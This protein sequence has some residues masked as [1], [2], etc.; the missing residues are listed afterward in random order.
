MTNFR[1]LKKPERRYSFEI[2]FELFGVFFIISIATFLIPIF[3][4]TKNPSMAKSDGFFS[5]IDF[6]Y[7]KHNFYPFVL[8]AGLIG[9]VIYWNYQ[10]RKLKVVGFDFEENNVILTCRNSLTG[11][12][13]EINILE[14]NFKVQKIHDLYRK[15]HF[16]IYNNEKYCCSFYPKSEVWNSASDKET[17]SQLIALLTGDQPDLTVKLEENCQVKSIFDKESIKAILLLSFFIGL[18]IY[19]FNAIELIYFA[20]FVSLLLFVQYVILRAIAISTFALNE[21]HV[22]WIFRCK[23]RKIKLK[24]SD[25]SKVSYCHTSRGLYLIRLYYHNEKD[26][27]RKVECCFGNTEQCYYVLK[28]VQTN[29]IKIEFRGLDKEQERFI[30]DE[31]K[32]IEL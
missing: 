13:S 27:T 31:L 25:L 14:S 30:F 21:I 6:F 24:Y 15:L 32:L 17:V 5:F 3:M 12:I 2:F 9:T 29:G 26:K 18:L 1:P 4:G 22:F 19:M 28:F 23:N 8:V 7:N 16:K 11:K 10:K 20:F